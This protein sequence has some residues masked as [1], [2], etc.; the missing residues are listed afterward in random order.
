[1]RRFTRTPIPFLLLMAFLLSMGAAPAAA[2]PLAANK[3]VSLTTVSLRL[4]P[5]AGTTHI[6]QGALVCV[7]G[8]GYAV[9]AANTANYRFVGVAIHGVDNSSG[10]NGDLSVSVRTAGEITIVSSGLTQA[11][12]GKP[13]YASDDQTVALATTNAIYVGTISSYTSAT[14]ARIRF[15]ADNTP[16]PAVFPLYINLA[17]MTAAGDVLT[18]WTPGFSGTIEKVSWYQMAPVTTPTKAAQINLEINTTNV[19]G[20]VVSLTSATCTPLGKV[21][22]GTAVTAANTF[23]ADDTISIEAASVTAF[24]EGDGVLLVVIRAHNK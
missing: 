6:Y 14:A 21:I 12:V 4:V 5:V 13:V 16:A 24:S 15:D 17:S 23:D 20:G 7:N 19:T 2:T 11:D 1:M 3:N 18:N 10:A 22:D 8:S 9:P